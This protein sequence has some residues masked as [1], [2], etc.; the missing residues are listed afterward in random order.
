MDLR[1]LRYFIK[2]VEC[3]NITRASE[4]L[5]IAQPAISQQMRNLERDLQ[6]LLLER[7]AHGVAPT[8]AG[9]TLYRHALDLLR[10]ADGTRD[11]L[12]QDAALPQGKVS[13]AMPSS[14]SR[15]LAVS[16][17]RTVR[18][19][20]PGIVLEVIEAPSADI[21][22]LINAGRVDLAVMADHLET[23]GVIA[24]RL[25]TEALYLVAWPGFPIDRD[26]VPLAALADMPL[27]LPSAPN[28]IRNRIE[29]ALREAGLSC[30]I[31]F[32]ASSTALL[33]EA[34]IAQLGVTIL[35]WPAAHVEV[36]EHKLTLT[37]VDHRLFSRD[38]SLCWHDTRLSSSLKPVASLLVP[39][40]GLE[41][42]GT[43]RHFLERN[44][45]QKVKASL[46]EMFELLG[47]RPEWAARD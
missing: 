27:I 2:V 33:L 22:V 41:H 46:L 30:V 47:R 43:A 14:T 21:G 7:S 45:V 16:L 19:R 8:A 23:H 31:R 29:W 3:G 4:A 9:Q 10:Q 11:L 6:I 24:Q 36:N 18:E 13:V 35:P 38:L 28:S 40:G 15:V 32:E 44:A 12:L 42:L 5:H 25:I 39:Q 20:Y 1:Q 34:V 37:R 26:S 17:M